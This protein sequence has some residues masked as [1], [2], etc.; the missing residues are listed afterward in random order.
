M[1]HRRRHAH[2]YWKLLLAC[3]LAIGTALT[4]PRGGHE[5]SAP[6]HPVQLTQALRPSVARARMTQAMTQAH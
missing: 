1:T 2:Q 6:H 5:A 4:A 3:M